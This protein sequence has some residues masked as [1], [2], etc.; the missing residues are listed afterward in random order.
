MKYRTL[1]GT[2]L[3]E[4]VTVVERMQLHTPGGQTFSA[5]V[6]VLLDTDTAATVVAAADAA[7]YQAKATGRNRVVAAV[8]RRA[9]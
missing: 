8:R 9:R 6:A 4:A 3:N 2:D 1:P 5:G 7:M